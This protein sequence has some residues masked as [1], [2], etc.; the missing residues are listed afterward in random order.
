MQNKAVLRFTLR[1]AVPRVETGVDSSCCQWALGSGHLGL[2]WDCTCLHGK[3]IC[4]RR[5]I[6]KASGKASLHTVPG[7]VSAANDIDKARPRANYV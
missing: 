5:V 4:T 2:A 7:Q 3:N 1:V 6:L